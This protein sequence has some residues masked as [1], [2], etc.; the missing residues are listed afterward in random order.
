MSHLFPRSWLENSLLQVGWKSGVEWD[1][2]QVSDLGAEVVDLSLESLAGLL[3]LLL[4]GE[5]EEDVSLLLL[6]HVDLDDGSDGG[7]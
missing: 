1:T 5:E 6:T 3:Y 2:L 4:A 7:L